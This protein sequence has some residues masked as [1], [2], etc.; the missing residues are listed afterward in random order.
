MR[1]ISPKESLEKIFSELVYTEGRL[2]A[3]SITKDLSAVFTDLADQCVKINTTTTELERKETLTQASVDGIKDT[4]SDLINELAAQLKFILRVEDNISE[5]SRW[6]RYFR[7]PPSVLVR[8]GIDRLIKELQNWSGSLKGEPEKDLQSLGVK[9]EK[10]LKEALT[11]V[12]AFKE[13]EAQRKDYKTRIIEPLVEKINQER[14]KLMGT[15][16][17]RKVQHKM[18]KKWEDRFM[19]KLVRIRSDLPNEIEAQ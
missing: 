15:L 10:T 12:T 14:E 18:P 4:L 7:E 6:L 3:E 9:F 1:T 8:M 13:I 19:K 2:L 16:L 5:S 17:Q 11:A